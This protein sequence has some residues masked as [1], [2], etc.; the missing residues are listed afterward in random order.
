[1]GTGYRQTYYYKGKEGMERI[2]KEEK[3]ELNGALLERCFYEKYLGDDEDLSVLMRAYYNNDIDYRELFYRVLSNMEVREEFLVHENI[4][5][6]YIVKK[7]LDGSKWRTDDHISGDFTIEK[8]RRWTEYPADIIGN[9]IWHIET[10]IELAKGDQKPWELDFSNDSR[11]H[12]FVTDKKNY[13]DEGLAFLKR[14]LDLINHVIDGSKTGPADIIDLII[15]NWS[16][17]YRFS[18]IYTTLQYC[19]E[20]ADHLNDS[21]TISKSLREYCRNFADRNRKKTLNLI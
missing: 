3:L 7:V 12:E 5:I 20:F 17:L 10:Q 21:E 15:S 18:N 19:V 8:R 11:Y 6:V 1:M 4:G 14:K 16:Y 13:T 9:I 2:A